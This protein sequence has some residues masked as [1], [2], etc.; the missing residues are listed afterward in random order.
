MR[1]TDCTPSHASPAAAGT[2]SSSSLKEATVPGAPIPDL[3]GQG[4]LCLQFTTACVVCVEVRRFPK[5]RHPAPLGCLQSHHRELWAYAN[6][7]AGLVW[8]HQSDGSQG[9]TPLAV[10]H[11]GSHCLCPVIRQAQAFAPTSSLWLSTALMWL[12]Q[13]GQGPLTASQCHL[14]ALF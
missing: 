13:E 14:G 12:R 3:A 11:P 5:G 1:T 2:A 4:F 7:T 9:H 10:P 8:T 6:T